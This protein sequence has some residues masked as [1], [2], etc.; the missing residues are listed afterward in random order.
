MGTLPPTPAY[1]EGDECPV[2]VD[3]LFGG[4]TPKYVEID[5]T[6]LNRCP[7]ATEDP[8]DGTYLLTQAAPCLWTLT[9]GNRGYAWR[10][11]NGRSILRLD[12]IGF[13]NF[14]YSSVLE[15]CYDAFANQTVCGLPNDWA[16]D[17]YV[18]CWW[19]PTIGP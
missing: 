14:F 5:V 7:I 2:C 18:T 6:G 9:V 17:G 15:S 19:G 13:F 3:L 8:P 1:E 4:V 12:W 11:L 10:L 16:E